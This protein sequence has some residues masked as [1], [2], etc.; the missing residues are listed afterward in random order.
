MPRFTVNHAYRAERSDANLTVFGPWSAGE[1][2]EVDQVDADWINADSQGALVPASSATG[3][4]DGQALDQLTKAQLTALAAE[5]SVE[6]DP[7]AT[8]A[9]LVEALTA[10]GDPP[11]SSA[12]GT[13]D[14]QAQTTDKPGA[15]STG[16]AAGLTK[17]G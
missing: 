2:V 3:T 16:D 13:P 8:K 6:V 17:G 11:A 14:G 7:K 5:R 4:P 12:T 1:E 10:A 15:H 9:D